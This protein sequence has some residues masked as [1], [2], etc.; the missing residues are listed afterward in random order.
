MTN[1]AGLRE[2]PFCL[3][4]L[5]S[6]TEHI[7]FVNHSNPTTQGPG[8]LNLLIK[9]VLKGFLSHF[10]LLHCITVIYIYSKNLVHTGSSD[11]TYEA[12][13]NMVQTQEHF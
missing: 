1:H 6:C 4:I 2:F 13:D 5:Y 10:R 3:A 8:P 9:N 11:C 7:Y 12:Y